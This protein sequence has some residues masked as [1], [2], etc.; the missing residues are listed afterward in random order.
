MVQLLP[1]A[2]NVLPLPATFQF[3]NGTII[4][5]ATIFFVPA[6]SSFNSLMVQLLQLPTFAQYQQCHFSIP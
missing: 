4:T 2:T 3:P 1:A 5:D 6:M